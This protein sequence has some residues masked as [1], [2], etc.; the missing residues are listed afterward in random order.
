MEL[1]PYSKKE[2]NLTSPTIVTK[3]M[4]P[5]PTS[6]VTEVHFIVSFNYVHC[7]ALLTHVWK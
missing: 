2:D 5:T 3:L 6:R 7:Y 4:T 1:C